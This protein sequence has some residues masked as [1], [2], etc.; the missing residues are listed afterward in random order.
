[1]ASPG[2]RLFHQFSCQLYFIEGLLLLFLQL[3][4]GL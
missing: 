2:G 3:F 1:M 4:L